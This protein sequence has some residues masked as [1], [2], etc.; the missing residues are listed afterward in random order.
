VRSYVWLYVG[1]GV[2]A[3]IVIDGKLFHGQ[4]GFSGEIGHC[5]VSEDGPLCGCGRRGCLETVAST[6]ALLRAAQDAIE[7]KQATQLSRVEGRL[8]VAGIAAAAEGDAVAKRILAQSSEHLGRGISFLLNILNPE[9]IVLG[10]P[11]IEA[12]EPFLHAVRAS[13]AHHALLPHGV[14][15]VPS[16]L[17]DRAELTGSVLLAMESTVRSYRIVGSHDVRARAATE[18]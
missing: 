14:A 12:G 4:S 10:G 1:S 3:G 11:A 17:A 5:P 7:G 9:M 18:L 8:D 6:M 16:T 2:G 15:I 13:V